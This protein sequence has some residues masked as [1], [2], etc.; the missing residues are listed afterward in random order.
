[1]S[2]P[3][4]RK[5]VKKFFNFSWAPLQHFGSIL[6]IVDNRRPT[7]L[8]I[9]FSTEPASH[10]A[11]IWPKGCP[12]YFLPRIELYLYAFRLF[13]WLASKVVSKVTRDIASLL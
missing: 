13:S 1:V 11:Y 4:N 10:I 3:R 9:N 5:R 6:Y 12:Q 8:L 7:E 2:A